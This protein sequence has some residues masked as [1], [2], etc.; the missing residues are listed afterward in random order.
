MTDN[1]VIQKLV[2]KSGRINSNISRNLPNDIK[3]YLE[4]RFDNITS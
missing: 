2:T 4:Q 3:Q 1:E